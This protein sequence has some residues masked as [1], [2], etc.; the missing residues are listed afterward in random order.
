MYFVRKNRSDIHFKLSYLSF[1]FQFFNNHSL[2]FNF[3]LK[4]IGNP[5]CIRLIKDMLFI[6]FFFVPDRVLLGSDIQK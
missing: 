6:L 3:T 1:L 2:V 4:S 5:I